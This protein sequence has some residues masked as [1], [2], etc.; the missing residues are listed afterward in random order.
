VPIALNPDRASPDQIHGKYLAELAGFDHRTIRIAEDDGL[1]A[2]TVGKQERLVLV[3]E[4]K[5][6]RPIGQ[7][8]DP[9]VHPP[10]RS[11]I[12]NS[13]SGHSR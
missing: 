9:L 8:L 11:N 6:R 7:R 4:A 12:H 13:P 2:S 1:C 10:I 5:V 3:Q